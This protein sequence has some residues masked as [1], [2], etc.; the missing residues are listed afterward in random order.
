M[1][2]CETC[3]L[4][5]PAQAEIVLEGYV[6]LG[7][8]RREGPFGDHTATTRSKTITRSSTSPALPSGAS[9]S[10]PRRS[11][12]AAHGGLFMGKAMERIF[13]PLMR[14]QLPRS[15]TSRCRPRGSSTIDVGGDAQILSRP[16]RKVMHA[17]WGMGQA[18][19]SKC[20]VVVDET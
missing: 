13:L 7:E 18:M 10:T 9:R 11:S 19:F 16:R 5:V 12:A 4:E 15:A 6:E 2:K 1:V 8:L 14:L 17:I 3:D 20:I